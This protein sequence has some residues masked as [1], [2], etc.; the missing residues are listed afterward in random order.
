MDNQEKIDNIL[1]LTVE[2]MKN[3][4]INNYRVVREDGESYMVTADLKTDRL[5][6]EIYNDIIT[7]AYFG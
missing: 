5:N 4:G 1:G 3:L 7:N 6:L 2:E